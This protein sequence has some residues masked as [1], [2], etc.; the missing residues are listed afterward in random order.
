MKPVLKRALIVI[1]VVAAA[2]VAYLLYDNLRGRTTVEKLAGIIHDEDTRVLTGR[3]Q[4]FLKDDS[5]QIRE[6]AALAVGRIGGEKSAELLFDLIKDTSLDVASTAAF[7]IG[8]TG[9]KGYSQRLLQQADELPGEVA[10]SAVLSAGR[11]SDSTQTDFPSQLTAFLANGSPSVREAACYAL[12]YA[13]GK[14]QSL[15]L[16]D[17]LSTEQDTMVQRAALFTLARLG[18]GEA[19]SIYFRNLADADPYVRSLCIRGLS[20]SH[21]PSALQYLA[22]GLN[23]VDPGVEAQA[24]AGLGSKK[25]VEAARY[26]YRRL[27]QV[28]D[29]NVQTEMIDALQKANFLPATDMINAYL[30]PGVSPNVLASCLRF[31]ATTQKDRAVNLLDSILLTK[32]SARVRAAGAEAYGMMEQPLV[33]PRVA[34]LF[35]DPSPQVRSAAFD[36][37]T[38][39]DSSNLEFYIN[40]ALADTDFVL[41]AQAI[42]KIQEKKLVKYIPNLAAMMK[43][44]KEIEPDVRRG[45]I[46]ALPDLMSALGHD[47]SL[48]RILIDGILDKSYI[49]RRSAA[50]VYENSLHEDKGKLVPPAETRISEKDI[51]GALAQYATNPYAEIITNRGKIKLE[52]Y[53]DQAPLTVMNFISLVKSGF[54]T[55]LIFHRVVPNFVIQGGDPRGDGWGGPGY[56][57]RCEY[58][59]EPYIKGTVGIATSGK[60]TGG[61]Q[62]FITLSPQPHLNARY[63]VFGQVTSGMDVA[64]QIVRGDTI[65]QITIEDGK[66]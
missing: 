13:K 10:A 66:L 49:V 20:A 9:A 18:V 57:I 65:Q 64:E 17:L 37:L 55:G 47:S 23:D 3:L 21:D 38:T 43:K 7:A 8:L 39:L 46:E 11:L 48:I 44:P 25:S 1:L 5:L 41:Q 6:R 22:I 30:N 12:F 53:F 61:S 33:V 15:A 34:G 4:S 2:V 58:S 28:R 31:Y 54:Y 40:K 42:S 14:G 59:D 36:V 32:P 51:R 24:V 26:I 27:P 52:L 35:S 62:F 50:Q 63:T 56:Y 29:E 45:I 60:D 19:T 16:I